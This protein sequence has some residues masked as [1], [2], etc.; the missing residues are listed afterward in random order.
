MISKASLT[1]CIALLL[2]FFNLQCAGASS[3]NSGA[4]SPAPP[5]PAGPNLSIPYPTDVLTYH[6][7]VFRQGMTLQETTLTPSNVNM[8][9][10]GKVGFLSVDGKVDA[11]PLYVNKQFING[12]LN[13]TVYT[14]TENDSV[15]A[16]SAETGRQFWRVSVLQSGETPSD[17]HGCGQISPQIGITNTPVIDKAA[18]RNGAIYFVA[19][20]KDSSGHYHQRLHALD[21]MSGAE[22][23]GGPTEIQATYPGT[24][25]GSQNGMV[26][27]NPGQFAERAG[28]LEFGTTIYLA[29]TSHCDA[30]PYTGWVMAYNA[31]TLAQT[32]VIDVTPNGNEG[33]IWMT[34]DGLA[35]DAQG[36]IYFLDGNGTFDT[37]LNAQ[38]FPING[39]FGNA[40]VKLNTNGSGQLQVADYF[41]MFNTVQE[42]NQDEDLGSG[43]VLIL[44][45]LTDNNGQVHHLAVGAGKDTNIYVVNRDNMGK[46]NASNNNQVYQ[47]IQGALPGGVWSK[48]AYFSNTVYYGDV[49]DNLKAYTISNAKL[50][51]A[52]TSQTTN[53]FPYPGTTPS[54]SSNQGTNGIVWAVANSNPAVLYAFDA[55]NLAHQL[56][57]SNQAGTRDQFGPGNKFITPIVANGR[58]FVGTQ[59]GVAVFGLL[60]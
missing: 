41:N 12:S 28:L 59:T 8:T 56:Y 46:W 36:N 16:F 32:S 58:V 54:V 27:F 52:P 34:G 60:Q 23:F 22:L 51:T 18:G 39:D 9:T 11:Q 37:T 5:D 4:A 44:P 24:G 40:F 49:G 35:A 2:S 33:A 7:N 53:S 20:T 47:E 1:A 17:D 3:S 13:D 21:L 6:Y 45:D 50:S 31:R 42:S 15:Y 26:I 57:N 38:G 30:R 14:V 55:T 43:G 19:M 10:F 25:D 29:F 48:P